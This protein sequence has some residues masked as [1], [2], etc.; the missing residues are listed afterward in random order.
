MATGG[1]GDVLAGILAGLVA[2][3][4]AG[5]PSL[6]PTPQPNDL[7]EGVP[8]AS[9][10]SRLLEQAIALGVYLHGLA[11]DQAAERQGEKSLLAS[12]IMACL[13]S[14]FLKLEGRAPAAR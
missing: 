3:V 6:E 8:E 12:D 7:R 1:S 2:Q 9:S 10:E 5:L 13:P 14:A 4:L 11:G